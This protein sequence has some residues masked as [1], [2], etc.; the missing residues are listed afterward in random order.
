MTDPNFTAISL[1]DEHEGLWGDQADE[2][3][4]RYG[5]RY[6]PPLSAG[7]GGGYEPGGVAAAFA[8]G[9][10]LP[11]Y[12]SFCLTCHNESLYSSTYARNIQRIDWSSLGGDS[13]LSGDK[14]GMNVYTQ[15]LLMRQPYTDYAQ[16]STG[17]ILSCLDCHEPHGASNA[18]LIR[19][20]VNGESLSGTV[21]DVA[22]STSFGY[23][24]RQCHQD[25]YLAGNSV[26]SSLINRW[27]TVHHLGSDRPYVQ[28]MCSTCHVSS[29]G[30]MGA[31]PIGCFYC[32]GHGQYVDGSHPGIL[33]NGKN[34]PAPEG[35]VRQ[36]F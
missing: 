22:S 17:Y 12:N 10:Q 23:L 28:K 14:H 27:E 3:M 8:D 2:T 13:I 5:D 6:Q 18:F 20:G 35:G 31:A 25:D 1:P 7:A 19:R 9:S 36:A 16:Q 4:A 11:D 24:C 30:G 21:S 15:E 33:P 34:I 26:D 32:H 29:G